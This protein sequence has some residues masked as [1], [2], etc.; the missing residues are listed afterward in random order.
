[1]NKSP[2]HR[3][4]F[5]RIFSGVIPFDKVLYPRTG[6]VVAAINALKDK[7]DAIYDITVVYDNHRSGA[8]SMTGK[9]LR[10]ISKKKNESFVEYLQGQIDQLHIH[11]KRID[12][13]SIPTRNNEEIAEWLVQRFAAKD[14]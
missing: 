1:M 14:K 13:E 12:I 2:G 3:L 9:I 6:A 7:F 11:I 8:P 10:L 4:S 5:R